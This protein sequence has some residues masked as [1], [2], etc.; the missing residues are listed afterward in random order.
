[1]GTIASQITSL[2]IV[3][4]IVYS[5]ADQRIHQ[6]SASLAFRGIHRRPVNS[7][8]KWP[9]T[10][11][12][13][14]SMTSSWI[15]RR[16]HNP[17]KNAKKTTAK[18]NTTNRCAHFIWYAV[19]VTLTSH[20][21]HGVLNHCH[22]DSI[23]C[24]CSQLNKTSKLCITN[25]WWGEPLVTGSSPHKGPVIRKAFLVMT[26]SCNYIYISFQV[27]SSSSTT[28]TKDLHS[29]FR[30]QR[31]QAWHFQ[32]RLARH[33][34]G[35]LLAEAGHFHQQTGCPKV[36]VQCLAHTS[37]QELPALLAAVLQQSSLTV[38][39]WCVT[40]TALLT[41]SPIT[42]RGQVAHICHWTGSSL[43]QIMVCHIFRDKPLA[44]PMLAWLLDHFRNA[45]R[46][47]LNPIKNVIPSRKNRRHLKITSTI[48]FRSGPNLLMTWNKHISDFMSF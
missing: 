28:E 11:K 32:R 36:A 30:R 40:N 45:I 20:E 5:D 47:N 39:D 34:Q 1:M 10:R 37:G 18:E 9:V 15:I 38:E 26:S 46:W 31:T 48:F 21:R 8:H 24:S 6:S 3:Y 12:S 17:L 35:R 13:F 22:I 33:L 27:P 14:H 19:L 42:R 4:S 2:T 29:L 44:E 23:A 43:V 25:P 16:Y 7:P 41:P